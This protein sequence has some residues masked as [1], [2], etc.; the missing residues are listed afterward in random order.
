MVHG[1]LGCR[2]VKGTGHTHTH[3][4]SPVYLGQAQPNPPQSRLA[5]ALPQSQRMETG[6][7]G[8]CWGTDCHPPFSPWEAH[9]G[10]RSGQGLGKGLLPVCALPEV[11]ICPS[12]PN[13]PSR[14][15]RRTWGTT[16]TPLL[17]C[18]QVTPPTQ[19]GGK[20]VNKDWRM[21]Q[22]LG[23][24]SLLCECSN[25]PPV[26]RDIWKVG[27]P[28]WIRPVVNINYTGLLSQK[29][30]LKRQTKKSTISVSLSPF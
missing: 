9:C 5:S 6:G 22:H 12:S 14:A 11:V 29:S 7:E 27:I 18:S 8:P 13:S 15:S 20:P 30:L 21:I 4:G 28:G 10:C 23:L 17:C 1:V 24:S 26:K 3:T 16:Q 19:H 25:Y 2:S